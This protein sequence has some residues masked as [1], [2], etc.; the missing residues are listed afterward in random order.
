[1]WPTVSLL[2]FYNDQSLSIIGKSSLNSIFHHQL[3]FRQDHNIAIHN[4][5][6][7][8]QSK[9]KQGLVKC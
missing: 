1:M 8:V 6:E 7:M 4:D 3:I 5:H 9:K 2:S